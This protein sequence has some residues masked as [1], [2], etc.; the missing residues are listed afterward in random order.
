MQR[1]MLALAEA[2]AAD[3][4]TRI[5][6]RTRLEI[7]GLCLAVLL[8]LATILALVL[9]EADAQQRET[10]EATE[11]GADGAN[12]VAIQSTFAPRKNSQY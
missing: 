8:A 7:N 12:R 4:A 10:R 11:D 6:H 1:V 9:V 3:Y 5:I 2:V